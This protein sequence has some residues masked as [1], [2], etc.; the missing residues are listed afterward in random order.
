MPGGS[1]DAW[2]HLQEI[3][4]EIAAQVDGL[5]CCDWVGEGGAGHFVKMVHNGIEYGDMQLI[6]EAY[7]LMHAGLAMDATEIGEVF[8]G[9]RAGKL[10]S[11]LIDIT[12]EIFTLK[13]DDGTP[14][15]EKILDVAGQKAQAS[16]PSS[17]PSN[18]ASPS[19]SS[20]RRSSRDSSPRLRRSASP[21]PGSCGDRR[22]CPASTATPP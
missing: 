10:D 12:A 7:H 19:R 18:S 22:S 5:P 14:L 17:M 6:T 3:L 13:D 8:S 9:W 20:A 21:L 4:Q 1:R 16:G 15:V 11:Y 2:P